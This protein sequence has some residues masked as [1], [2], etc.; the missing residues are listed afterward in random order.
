VG[1]VVGAFFFHPLLSQ[2][3]RPKTDA[4]EIV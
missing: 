1:G 4:Q 2:R 3:S